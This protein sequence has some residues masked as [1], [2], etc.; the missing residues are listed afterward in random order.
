MDP[1]VLAAAVANALVAA[2]TTDAWHEACAAVVGLWRRVFP[3][4]ADTVGAELDASRQDAL[5]A[6]QYDNIMA[7]KGIADVWNLRLRRLLEAAPGSADELQ[8]ILDHLA[9]LETAGRPRPDTVLMKASASNG[10]RVY[11]AGRDQTIHG[12]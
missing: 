12:Q 1:A 4:R 7:E 8:R 9:A 6:L 11:Q 5:T 3:H 10:G 2:M